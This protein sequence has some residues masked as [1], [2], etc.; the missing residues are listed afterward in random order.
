MLRKSLCS[1]NRVSQ[2]SKISNLLYILGKFEKITEK[3]NNNNNPKFFGRPQ[4]VWE[5]EF[6]VGSAS[7]FRG[8]RKGDPDTKSGLGKI[9]IARAARRKNFKFALKF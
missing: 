7:V 9:V 6:P 3:K 1:K 4:R 5:D 8:R 2:N